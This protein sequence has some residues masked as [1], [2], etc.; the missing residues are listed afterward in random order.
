MSAILFLGAFGTALGFLVWRLST[1]KT[2]PEGYV[3]LTTVSGS[4]EAWRARRALERAHIPVIVDSHIG[5]MRGGY[6]GV[7]H[8]LVPVGQAEEAMKVLKESHPSTEYPP[9]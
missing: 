7:A 6:G 5:M 4:V 1:M 9:V 3:R 2:D 8:V